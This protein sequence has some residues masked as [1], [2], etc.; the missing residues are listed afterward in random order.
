MIHSITQPNFCPLLNRKHPI[1]LKKAKEMNDVPINRKNES[2]LGRSSVFGSVT[3]VSEAI[4]KP[5]KRE[6]IPTVKPIPVSVYV[7][8][9]ISFLFS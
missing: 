4:I 1:R 3:V 8:K 6:N 5:A 7:R 9:I 2:N